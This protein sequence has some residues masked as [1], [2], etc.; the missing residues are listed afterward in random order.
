MLGELLS[1]SRVVAFYK[2]E[3][4]FLDWR[5]MVP[6]DPLKTNVHPDGSVI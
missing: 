1:D 6:K 2:A 4:G 5:H 3:G